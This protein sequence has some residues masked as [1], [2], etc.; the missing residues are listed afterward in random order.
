MEPR[1][2]S[3]E[4]SVRIVGWFLAGFVVALQALAI[5]RASPS[6]FIKRMPDD[7]FYYLEVG[8]RL[9]E[10]GGFTFDGVHE[11]NGF[12]PLWQGIVALLSIVAPSDRAYIQLVL[13][14]GL[15]MSVAAV[16]L[17][18]RTVA[19]VAGTTAALVGSIVALTGALG[20]WSNGMEGPAVMLSFAIVLTLLVRWAEA[21]TT[22]NGVWVGLACALSVLARL[23]VV[24][25]IW[26]VPAAMAWRA[27]AWRAV[28]PVA[29][30][31]AAI[32]IP[33]GAAWLI[34]FGHPLTTS[35]TV[36]SHQLD[37][38]Y[39]DRFGGRA[40]GAYLRYLGDTAADYAR[41]LIER[42]RRSDPGPGR[43]FV[44]FL[45]LIGAAG[46]VAR[47]RSAREQP[48]SPAG[49][50][51]AVLVVVVLAKAVVD[52]LAAPLWASSWYA[53]P[54]QLV[55]PFAVGVGAWKG[56][57]WFSGRM[58]IAGIALAVVLGLLVV[59]LNIRESLTTADDRPYQGSWQQELTDA[60]TWIRSDGPTG[61]YGARDAGLLGFRL[62]GART[63]V[64][65]DGLV[66]NYD[67]AELLERDPTLLQQADANGVDF[68]VTR[69]AAEQVIGELGCAD[70]L[71]RSDQPVAYDD[72]LQGESNQY[73]YVLDLRSC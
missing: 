19:K 2:L 58:P 21:P 59:P 60:A 4:P 22:R 40:T 67:Y 14:T 10:G 41:S 7:A 37:E 71:W 53:A 63:L 35:A 29:A 15:V 61:R 50:A 47:R 49:F 31:A 30:G 45:A 54:Q 9:G 65:L 18:A 51:I 24:A 55:V 38:Q 26:L 32:G 25:V 46:A 52:L 36:K 68:L 70:Q 20:A 56:V 44:L 48:I 69:L 16:A 28:L 43:V 8:Q 34:R 12:H 73:I 1:T 33:L 39:Q 13:L 3:D 6:W 23:D 42:V 66:N 62:H 64:N 27:R 5:L 57:E 17:V 72:G 11:T